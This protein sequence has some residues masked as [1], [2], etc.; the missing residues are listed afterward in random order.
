MARPLGVGGLLSDCLAT[1]CGPAAARRH[2]ARARPKRARGSFQGQGRHSELASCG[3]GVRA[4]V[5]VAQSAVDEG[6]AKIAVVARRCSE[7][8]QIDPKRVIAF[9]AVHEHICQSQTVPDPGRPRRKCGLWVHRA[10]AGGHEIRRPVAAEPVNLIASIPLVSEDRL[11][12]DRAAPITRLK[13]RRSAKRQ[14]GRIRRQK[15]YVSNGL[16]LR[17]T[18]DVLHPFSGDEILVQHAH[19]SHPYLDRGVGVFS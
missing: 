5:S 14:S 17:V 3:A 15:W 6:L 8:G 19:S 2:H 16:A 7:W 13:A 4:G 12:H 9:A 11:T 10:R 1:L 18:P